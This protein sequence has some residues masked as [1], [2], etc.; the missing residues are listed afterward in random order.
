MARA[1]VPGF[2]GWMGVACDPRALHR[3]DGSERGAACGWCRRRGAAHG[4]CSAASGWWRACGAAGAA[5]TPIRMGRP[6]VA[7]PCNGE[8]RERCVS[9]PAVADER[10]AAGKL[11]RAWPLVRVATDARRPRRGPRNGS[12]RRREKRSHG[13][14]ACENANAAEVR[15]RGWGTARRRW[16]WGWEDGR[17]AGTGRAGRA[18]PRR[19]RKGRASPRPGTRMWVGR[20]RVRTESCAARQGHV[21]PPVYHPGRGASTARGCAQALRRARGA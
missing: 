2:R 18:P 10:H 20:A 4:V 19:A 21:P 11:A 3:R 6:D 14:R 8:W 5:L 9:G 12:P 1:P 15:R 17:G 13:M 16:G 7:V